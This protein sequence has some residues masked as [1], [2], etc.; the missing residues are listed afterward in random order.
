MHHQLPGSG[1][2]LG[3][4]PG[5]RRGLTDDSGLGF[6]GGA[7]LISNLPDDAIFGK[8]LTKSPEKHGLGFGTFGLPLILP[9]ILVGLVVYMFL[10]PN[11]PTNQ[12]ALS[13][14]PLRKAA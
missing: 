10:R 14:G 3:C 12:P 1:E 9:A 4:R 6:G 5:A 7:M 11:Q 2:G 8:L 13:S